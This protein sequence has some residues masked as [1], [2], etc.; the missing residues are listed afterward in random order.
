MPSDGNG[1]ELPTLALVGQLGLIM[2]GSILLGC[3]AGRLLDGWLGTDPIFMIVMIL[4]GVLGGMFAV[5]RTVS[6]FIDRDGRSDEDAA[7]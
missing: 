3:L 7:T 2:V 5:Y 6:R 4:A 1:Q